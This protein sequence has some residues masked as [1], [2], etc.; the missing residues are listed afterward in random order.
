MKTVLKKAMCKLKKNETNLIT[1]TINLYYFVKLKIELNES[2]LI[3]KT[4]FAFCFIIK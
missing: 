2:L 4:R 3:D 1:Y